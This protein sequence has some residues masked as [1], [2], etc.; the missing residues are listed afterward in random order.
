MSNRDAILKLPPHSDEAEAGALGCVLIGGRDVFDQLRAEAGEDG[1]IFYDLRHREIYKAML[2]LADD[3]APIDTLTIHESLKTTEKLASIGG[4]AYLTG[5]PEQTPSAANLSYYVELLMEKYAARRV[6]ELATDTVREAYEG[7]QNMEEMLSTFEERAL[8]VRRG[9]KQSR[10]LAD[11]AQ[12]QMQLIE[13]Y[14]LAM[15]HGKAVGVRTG[16]P[17]LDHTLGGAMGQEVII[18]AGQ[19]S[20]GKTTL[21]LNIAWHMVSQFDTAIGFLSLETSAKKLVHRIL[22]SV[23]RVNGSRLLHG[24]PNQG[25][26][27]KIAVAQAKV[28]LNRS[29][30]FLSDSAEM[31]PAALKAQCR[32]MYHEG[33][34]VF[35]IDYLQLINSPGH[36]DY[37]R[38]T[39]GSKFAKQLAKEL[40]VPVFL[41]SSL[42]RQSDKKDSAP[43]LSHLRNSG[44]IE[45]DCDKA[46]LLE[47]EKSEEEDS[48]VRSINV[49]VAKNKDGPLTME[50]LVLLASEFR[51]ESSAGE[52]GR[53]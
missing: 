53:V 28:S 14:E 31:S 52:H 2:R 18:I 41:I 50:K 35:F 39:A 49:H 6:I 47:L 15:K 1:K 12:I 48:T 16:F 40:N 20:T 25:E 8:S 46:L 7:G 19:P 45:Y 21:A 42:S 29:K 24:R 44:Q 11:L 3:M 32:Q 37:E 30:I 27:E 17:D 36:S 34:R 26:I 13:D 51:F 5:L 10:G 22:C 38:T 4:L 9:L 23:A 33:A 43:R